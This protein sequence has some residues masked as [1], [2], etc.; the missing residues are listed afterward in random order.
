MTAVL[1][2]DA[3]S[4]DWTNTDQENMDAFLKAVGVGWAKRKL[5]SAMNYGI[6]SHQV[7]IKIDGDKLT[8]KTTGQR[9]IENVFIIGGGKQMVDS[10]D[11]PVQ[12]SAEWGSGSTELIV[13]TLMS[14]KEVTITRQLLD[15]STLEMRLK[16]GD[17]EA[18]RIFSK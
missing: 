18:K 2:Q 3:W 8:I 9:I 1:S 12:A 7:K 11:G 6:G 16:I 4:G 17:T 15:A 14:K 10:A 5:A 13:R